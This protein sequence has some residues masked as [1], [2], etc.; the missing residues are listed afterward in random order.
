MISVVL[1]VRNC[2]LIKHTFAI[3]LDQRV[4]YDMIWTTYYASFY[5][6]AP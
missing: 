4:T 5:M 6:Y 1:I 2:D 3:D